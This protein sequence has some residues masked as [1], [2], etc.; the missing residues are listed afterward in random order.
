[1]GTTTAIMVIQFLLLVSGRLSGASNPN[2]DPTFTGGKLSRQNEGNSTHND[3]DKMDPWGMGISMNNFII[4]VVVI[5]ILIIVLIGLL[6]ACCVY[7][8]CKGRSWGDLRKSEI[9][10]GRTPSRVDKGM[11]VSRVEELKPNIQYVQPPV[12]PLPPYQLH[13]SPSASNRRSRPDRRCPQRGGCRAQPAVQLVRRAPRRP[14][15]PAYTNA[16]ET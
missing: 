13:P 12:A 8:C 7:C 14:F 10:A 2:N 16:R 6:I 15:H 3:H 1:M 4:L 9:E 5:A 11:T